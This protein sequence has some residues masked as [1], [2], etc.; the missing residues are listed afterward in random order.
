[1]VDLKGGSSV[2]RPAYT[3]TKIFTTQTIYLLTFRGDKA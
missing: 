1:M 3:D 2:Y